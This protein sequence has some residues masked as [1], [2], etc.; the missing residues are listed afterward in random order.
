MT[1]HCLLLAG[2]ALFGKLFAYQGLGDLYIGEIVLLVGS[3]VSLASPQRWLALRSWHLVPLFGLMVW[4]AIRTAPYISI[5]GVEALRDALLHLIRNAIA[6]GIGTPEQRV[7]AGKDPV[8]LITLRAVAEGGTVKIEVED[9]GRGL[10]P[11]RLRV[12]AVNSRLLDAE[13]AQALDDRAALELIFIPGFSTRGNADLLAGRGIGLDAVADR[14]GEGFDFGPV[15]L[16]GLGQLDRL[17]LAAMGLEAPI[18]V[19][20]EDPPV[21]VDIE[22]LLGPLARAERGIGQAREAAVG[23]PYGGDEIVVAGVARARRADRQRL[24]RDRL[25]VGEI[26]EQV[27]EMARLA[28]VAPAAFRPLDP[29]V[30]GN[31]ARVDPVVHD[32][33]PGARG[34]QIAR[35][36]GEGR[37]AP[38]EAGEK[39]RL[40][41]VAAGVEGLDLGELVA[42]EAERLLDQHMRS[43]EHTSE[44]QSH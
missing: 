33:R 34:E 1:L 11:A 44:L 27:V 4:G 29:V 16:V 36:P 26:G 2:Y 32:H 5:Y 23:E 30:A 6:H 17:R 18:V 43:E 37:E 42:G 25:G 9:D 3:L 38:V 12:A 22:K 8:G 41:F 10:D 7:A 14:V 31:M 24:D 21:G 19:D 13:A 20:F 28:Q 39:K 15:A 40:A 35:R